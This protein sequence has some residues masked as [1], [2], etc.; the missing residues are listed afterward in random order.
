MRM[1]PN[2]FWNQNFFTVFRFRGIPVGVK[3]FIFEIQNFKKFSRAQFS[4]FFDGTGLKWKISKF[5]TYV[6]SRFCR[7]C[8]RGLWGP[9]SD[10]SR[11]FLVFGTPQT[12]GAKSAE[13]ALYVCAKFWYLS[14]KTGSVKNIEN[15]ALENFLKYRISKIINKIDDSSYV[16]NCNIFYLRLVRQKIL[17]IGGEYG[18]WNFE[19]RKKY[20]DGDYPKIKKVKYFFYKIEKVEYW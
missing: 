15:C 5:R 4:I 2:D 7:F 19:F 10:P 9:E 20:A 12:P 6:Q 16:R 11:T 13:S 3:N 18:I 14:F 8:P 1:I 17:G